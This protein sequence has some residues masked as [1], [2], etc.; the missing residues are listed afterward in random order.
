MASR[1]THLSKPPAVADGAAISVVAPASFARKERVARGQKALRKVGFVP[2][3]AAH[4]LQRGPIYFAGDPDQRIADLQAAFADQSTSA[5]MCL[6]GGYGSNYLLDGLDLK[7]IALT[8]KPF[9]AYSDLTGLQ[10]RLLDQLG[11]PAF[12]GPMLA[13]DF[14]LED[15]VHMESFC[16]ALGGRSYTVGAKEGLRTLQKGTARGVLYGGCLS[17]LVSLLGTPWEPQTEGKLLFLEDV[18]AKPYQVDRMLWQLRHAGKLKGVRG[19]IFGEMLDCQSKDAPPELL[20]DA[21]LNALEG[22]KGPIAIGLRSG[23]VSRQNV[24][25]TFGVKADLVAGRTARLELLE[26]AVKNAGTR[27][28]RG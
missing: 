8:P 15:G 11:L 12:H 27:G 22:F 14:F 6:R 21:I 23:H 28:L 16:A 19:I 20:D 18:G 13:A 26:P 25:L 9:F 7:R 10:L 2:R 17:I 5:V 1:K 24:T 4:A 3:L